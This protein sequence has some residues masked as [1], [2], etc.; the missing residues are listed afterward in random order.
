[1]HL[2]C[3]H[4]HLISI[5]LWILYFTDF[6][7]CSFHLNV[8]VFIVTKRCDLWRMAFRSHICRACIM[9]VTIKPDSDSHRAETNRKPALE[10]AA[11]QFKK[12]QKTILF[13]I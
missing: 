12:K 13:T 7:L 1:M 3:M 8:S 11:E 10:T 4:E 5:L 9:E 6:N 2:K